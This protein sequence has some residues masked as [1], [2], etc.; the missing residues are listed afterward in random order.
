VPD[1]TSSPTPDSKNL[2]YIHFDFEEYRPRLISLTDSLVKYKAM[3]PPR[4]YR[5]F[6]TCHRTSHLD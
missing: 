6:F 2:V 4:K 1:P 3:V 5:Y